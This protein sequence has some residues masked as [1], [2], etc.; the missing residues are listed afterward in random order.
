MFSSETIFLLCLNDSF[1]FG[2]PGGL[3][4]CVKQFCISKQLF[5]EP[6]RY[7]KEKIQIVMTNYSLLPI[8]NLA[9]HKC[10]RVPQE[11]VKHTTIHKSIIQTIPIPPFINNFLLLSSRKIFSFVRKTHNRFTWK[12]WATFTT[13]R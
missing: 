9:H 12:D 3:L 1:S 7:L 4:H 6:S 5:L 8:I 10:F 2:A 13:F 11:V